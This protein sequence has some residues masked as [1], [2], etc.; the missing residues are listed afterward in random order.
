MESDYL[1]NNFLVLGER[2]TFSI[3]RSFG[4][5]EKRFSSNFSKANK[6]LLYNADNSYFL[7][8]EKKYLSLKSAI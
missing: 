5:P 7:L 2:D 4:A 1:K 6:S 3:N 8:L